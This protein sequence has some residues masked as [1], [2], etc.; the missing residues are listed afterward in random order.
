MTNFQTTITN[1]STTLINSSK[2]NQKHKFTN[3]LK[4]ARLKTKLGVLVT[5]K[6]IYSY[7]TGQFKLFMT[8][9]KNANNYTNNYKPKAST[10][11]KFTP[12]I[13]T[14]NLLDTL[15]TFT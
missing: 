7:T 9:C 10:T 15:Y 12:N 11:S 8:K 13:R 14:T 6:N 5:L 4:A 2:A 1:V 3:L